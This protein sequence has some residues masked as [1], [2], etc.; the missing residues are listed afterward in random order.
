MTG[1]E[2]VWHPQA[3]WSAAEILEHL[4]LAYSRTSERMQPL[5]EQ[6]LGEMRGRTSREWIGGVIVLK[7]GRIP[8]GRKAPEALSPK[9]MDP[10]KA[11]ALVE[12]RLCQLDAVTERCEERFGEKTRVLV[13]SILGPLSTSEWRRFHCVHT[14]HHMKQI[15]ALRRQLRL[16]H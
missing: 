9:G 15:E 11:R 14:F 8:A 5:L 6:D 3:K 2:L 4:S 13:H 7:L 12:E 1:D 10:A 16:I